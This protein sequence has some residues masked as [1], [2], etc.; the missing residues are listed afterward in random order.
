MAYSPL[1]IGSF[2]SFEEITRYLR[3]E[4]DRIA[5]ETQQIAEGYKEILYIAPTK[6]R[7]GMIVYA[8][9]TSWN[10]GGGAGLYEYTG[11]GATGWRQLAN[12][13]QY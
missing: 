8:D 6:P 11:A 3:L 7:V 1:P 9:G 10:P 2:S 4:L 12:G 13:T 5:A